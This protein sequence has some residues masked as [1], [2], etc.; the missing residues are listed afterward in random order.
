[1]D[2]AKPP[3]ST[4]GDLLPVAPLPPSD[5]LGRLLRVS[6]ALSA[7]PTARDV[8]LVITEEARKA[9]GDDASGV[10][11]FNA[12]H[13]RL[14]LLA[15]RGFPEPILAQVQSYRVDADN[16]LCAAVRAGEP[17]WIEG[18]EEF[19]KRFPNSEARVRDV[20]QPRPQSFACLPLMIEE[21]VIGGV[22]F[23]FMAPRTFSQDERNFIGLLAQHC[24]LGIERARLYE[25]AL[26]AIRARDDFL[27]IAG[28]EL[29]TPLATLLLQLQGVL[30]ENGEGIQGP[31]AERSVS[32][33][34]T[35]RRLIKLADDVLDVS[36]IRAGRLRLEVETMDLGQVV[37][38][39]STRTAE[40]TR[41][42]RPELRAAVFG[43]LIGRWDPLRIEQI[44]SNL[45][46]NACKYG[47]GKPI[48]VR[49]A[50]QGDIAEI[51]VRDSGIG[52]AHADQARIFE[53]F[54][55][56]VPPRSFSGLGLGLWITREIAR[57][58]GGDISVRS[59]L[60]GGAEFT[61]TL[62]LAPPASACLPR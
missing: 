12:P 24:A 29:R 23:S 49:V 53:R 38:E 56:A 10:W 9:L 50:R 33:I 28:H 44:V 61:V 62:P 54:E 15:S 35:A 46:T 1:M 34:R 40:G 47:D 25:Q 55:R 19:A 42:P 20:N 48:D 43:P 41:P 27:S 57:A 21:T 6:A 52:I 37:S 16:P 39:V 30:G 8:A 22:A 2:S 14:D 58:H 4:S 51:I 7:A 36:R 32:A 60:G 3:K 17:V 26:D 31:S 18:W 13:S 59:E 45:I 5:R 11:L